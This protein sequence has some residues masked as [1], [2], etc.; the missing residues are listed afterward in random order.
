ML[1]PSPYLVVENSQKDE[2]DKTGGSE[3]VNALEEEKKPGSRKI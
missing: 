3:W 2:R 1:I